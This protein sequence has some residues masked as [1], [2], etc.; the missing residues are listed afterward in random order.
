MAAW[1]T[2]QRR[3]RWYGR[4]DDTVETSRLT[5]NRSKH[6]LENNAFIVSK[7]DDQRPTINDQQTKTDN[8]SKIPIWQTSREFSVSALME[9][10]RSFF[11]DSHHLDCYR[12]KDMSKSF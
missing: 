9:D 6:F 5:S 11:E 10:S 1:T 8:K 7:N 3:S 12:D 2:R 4:M